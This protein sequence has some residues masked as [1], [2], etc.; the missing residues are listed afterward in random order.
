MM[1]IERLE[2]MR[3]VGAG[4]NGLRSRALFQADFEGNRKS[5]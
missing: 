3:G 4:R 5:W 2:M 1:C